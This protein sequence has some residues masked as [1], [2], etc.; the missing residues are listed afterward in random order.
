MK[1]PT[2]I[3][4]TFASLVEEIRRHRE[5]VDKVII[6]CRTYDDCTHIY[7]YLRS[8]LGKQALQPIGAPDLAR[9]RLV[10][11]YTACTHPTVKDIILKAFTDPHGV[12]RIVVATVAFGMGVDCPDV[13]RIIHWG[14]PQDIEEYVQET[15]RA[16]R[17]ALAILYHVPRP[18]NRFLDEHMKDYCKNKDTCRREMLLKDFDGQ[19]DSV[20]L[21]S[22]CDVCELKCTCS[23][24]LNIPEIKR[25][26]LMC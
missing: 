18:S 15:G 3:E 14:A 5:A 17:D 23:V 8:R 9:F 7:M 10:D 24:F 12:L 21:C 4:E 26:P 22:C 2:N 25:L 1:V 13:R 19:F 6:F 11:M 20:I 16:G